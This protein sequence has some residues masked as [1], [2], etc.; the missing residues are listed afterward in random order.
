ML[1][2]PNFE[3]LT[4]NVIL[5]LIIY[6]S[7]KLKKD[8]INNQQLS[9]INQNVK[10]IIT[11]LDPKE[12]VKLNQI[13][14]SKFSFAE[15][16]VKQSEED[17][18]NDKIDGQK[19]NDRIELH[20]QRQVF[21]NLLNQK[22]HQKFN[23]KEMF[24]QIKLPSH[25][26][27]NGTFP[28]SETIIFQN[29]NWFYNLYYRS[30]MVEFDKNK[31]SKSEMTIINIQPEIEYSDPKNACLPFFVEILEKIVVITSVEDVYSEEV[32]T[33][34]NP[35]DPTKISV[36]Q[37]IMDEQQAKMNGKIEQFTTGT[38]GQNSSSNNKPKSNGKRNQPISKLDEAVNLMDFQKISISKNTKKPKNKD[39]PADNYSKVPL[40]VPETIKS[41]VSTPSNMSVSVSKNLSNNS[42][43]ENSPNLNL[44]QQKFKKL[45]KYIIL[46]TSI[47][48]SNFMFLKNI[49]S[50]SERLEN[51]LIVPSLSVDGLQV[52]M[53]I[54]KMDDDSSENE[55]SDEKDSEFDFDLKSTDSNQ[56]DSEG[57]E[58][59][60]SNSDP[61]LNR[62]EIQRKLATFT[63]K[64]ETRKLENTI[65]WI[66]SENRST[67][68]KVEIQNQYLKYSANRNVPDEDF[69]DLSRLKQIS[70]FIMKNYN[71]FWRVKLF[72]M[73]TKI[74][75][76]LLVYC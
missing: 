42:K 33:R 64:Y 12:D 37:K 66:D 2:D 20:E 48:A 40:S 74:S 13:D 56:S 41:S 1:K 44:I 24:E 21:R 68:L 10:K 17:N 55:S 45:P 6:H 36:I 75:F 51:P 71:G 61:S 72:L 5:L 19:N 34:K 47:L 43:R 70:R 62:Q 23:Q 16:A 53:L 49:L 67:V 46:D 60:N 59:R 15:A 11:L 9:L 25:L 58:S 65:N 35:T 69:M 31:R 39:R 54:L 4:N 7:I 76:V 3:S 8:K 27:Q 30:L 50:K 38:I 29:F 18:D 73:V 14:T 32:A 28:S 52:L 26:S 63:N 22:I 57:A